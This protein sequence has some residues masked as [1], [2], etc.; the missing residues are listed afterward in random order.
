MTVEIDAAEKKLSETKGSGSSRWW[1]WPRNVIVGVYAIAGFG[2]IHGTSSTSVPSVQTGSG[3]SKS[4]SVVA[5][6]TKVVIAEPKAVDQKPSP[7]APPVAKPNRGKFSDTSWGTRIFQQRE[8]QGIDDCTEANIEREQ[9]EASRML[10]RMSR[11]SLR[12]AVELLG[13]PHYVLRAGDRVPVEY[14]QDN[15]TERGFAQAIVMWT[16]GSCAANSVHVT[17]SGGSAMASAD[18]GGSE[19]TIDGKPF[20]MPTDA[21]SCAKGRRGDP[22]CRL[23]NVLKLPGM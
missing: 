18:P 3:A 12:R 16:N 2:A 9:T 8:C 14:Y 21:F 4:D 20:A 22:L 19:C 5:G 6:P 7:L 1:R 13:Q 11:T 15:V 23:E 10:N 17:S